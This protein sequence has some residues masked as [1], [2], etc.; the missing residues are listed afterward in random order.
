MLEVKNVY[1]KFNLEAGLFAKFGKFVYAVNGLSFNIND[2]ESFGLVGESGC[3]KTTMAKI[4]V[5]VYKEDSGSIIYKTKD[6]ELIDYS[7]EK[8]DLHK[9]IR[10]KIKY[11]FQD[12]AKSL[13]PRMSIFEILTDGYKYSTSYKEQKSNK[14]ELIDEATKMLELVGLSGDDLFRRPTD[15]SG[16]QRQR[17]SIARALIMNPELLVCDEI[18]S[19]LDVSIQSQIINLLIDIKEKKKLSFLFIA[20]DLIVVSYFCD[21]IAVMYG[22]TIVEL[23][24]AKD[25]IESRLHPYTTL[26]YNSIPDITKSHSFEK[27]V[28]VVNPTI[29][30]TGCPF[31]NRCHI[32]K[33][34]CKE[35]MP[36]LREIN[37]NHFVA[38]FCI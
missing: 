19:A 8:K 10:S 29:E 25:I 37:K 24:S 4:L 14:K 13:N 22:G 21:R 18:V 2:N 5:Q 34:L 30:P 6:G 33:T 15:F 23:A 11:I 28:D 1:K 17:I 20:H 35:S 32:K 16:G 36:Q 38:C 31:Y 9:K 7:N 12:P 26:L 3:G 27:I